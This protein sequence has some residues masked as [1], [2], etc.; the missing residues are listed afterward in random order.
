[1]HQAL[2]SLSIGD[3][4]KPTN[5]PYVPPPIQR[6]SRSLPPSTAP[7]LP[8][9]SASDPS[10]SNTT[11]HG[12][13]AP[14]PGPNRPSSSAETTYS[15]SSAAGPSSSKC[16]NILPY[17]HRLEI[18]DDMASRAPPLLDL[19]LSSQSFLDAVAM[20]L[21]SEKPLYSVETVGS[22]TTI[23]R[24]DPW[25]GSAKIADIRW[26]KELPLKGKARDNTNST[27]VQMN[28]SRWKE[29]T[30][31]LKYGSLRNSRKFS[32]PHYSHFLKWKRSG[33]LYQ[34]TT[35]TC[36]GA[37]ATLESFDEDTAPKLKVF[38]NLG[39]FHESVPQLDHA[40]ISL[41]LLD[42]L[43]VTALLLVTE[44]DDWMIVARNPTSL[45]NHS[46][47][48]FPHTNS[49]STKAPASARQW[50]KI[51]YGEPL[52]PSLKTPAFD[53]TAAPR[54]GD[55]SDVLDISQP[56][57]LSTSIRQWRKIVYGEPLYPSL[58]PQSA[59]GLDIPPRPSTAGDTASISSESAYFPATPSSAPSTGFY[60][61]SF[62]DDSNK[63][64]PRINTENKQYSLPLSFSPTSISPIPSS[65]C[66]PMSSPPTA[67]LTNGR[68]EL[69]APPSSYNP[70]PSSQPWLHR[71]RSSPRLSIVTED[72]VSTPMASLD[73]QD[74]P[75]G[76]V[77]SRELSLGSIRPRQ[78]P[79]IPAS[80]EPTIHPALVPPRPVD[81]KQSSQTHQRTLPPT[82]GPVPRSPSATGHRHVRQSHSQAIPPRPPTSST[83]VRPSTATQGDASAQGR[84]QRH[85]K[86]PDELINWVRSTTRAHHRRARGGDDEGHASGPDDV[87]Y[88]APPPAYNAIDFS[89]PPQARSPTSAH[90]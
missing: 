74:P 42:H 70:P 27:M 47:D 45:G 81:E 31:F 34:C 51:M 49:A 80:R 77:R 18:V 84:R 82:P 12:S 25:D 54:G 53:R 15:H 36:R 9:P 79:S 55:D 6:L 24:S 89:T 22:S 59:N 62:L 43:F 67:L 71:S 52:Y 61:S 72:G 5:H 63:T 46:T 85:E 68:R 14:L 32:I 65:E 60:D 7:P 58:R 23:W 4:D 88:E 33:N 41:S 28:G 35:P 48:A 2:N 73:D 50:R 69:P 20:D 26:P 40:G 87:I 16:S 64:V 11:L 44:P 78:L 56:L 38:E 83:P 13:S 8:N 57:Q 37:V 1:M 17:L 3:S 76:T 21:A 75:N 29:T 30:N 86:D 39:S 19:K 66:I 10:F 90:I